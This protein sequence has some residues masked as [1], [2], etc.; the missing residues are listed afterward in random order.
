MKRQEYLDSMN[1]LCKQLNAL[2]PIK[3]EE[4]RDKLNALIAHMRDSHSEQPHYDLYWDRDVFIKSGCN[5]DKIREAVLHGDFLQFEPNED[6]EE[7]PGVV[8][9]FQ[10]WA[11]PLI[12]D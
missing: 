8:I 1:A 4:D 3:D 7:H 12:I 9:R 2:I 10:D 5:E 11:F 6:Y